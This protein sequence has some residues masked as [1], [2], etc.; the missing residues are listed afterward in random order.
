MMTENLPYTDAA[1]LMSNTQ[2]TSNLSKWLDVDILNFTLNYPAGYTISS[3]LWKWMN[4][5]YDE[6]SFWGCFK[7]LFSG[8]KNM[9]VS[10][11]G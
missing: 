10:G 1:S 6:T 7:N 2:V 4:L 9:L 3:D 8:G 5:R 11:K